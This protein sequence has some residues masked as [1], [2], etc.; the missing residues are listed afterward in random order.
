VFR[1]VKLKLYAIPGS[2]PCVAVEAALALKGLDYERVD[3]LPGLSPFHQLATFGKRTVPGMKIDGD[4]IVGSRLIMRALDGIAPEPPLYP[5]DADARAAAE[6]AERWGEEQLQ[7]AARW[8][9]VYAVG[10]R[11]ES[12]ASFTVGSNIPR[13]PG[14]LL[15]PLTRAIFAAELRVFA[16]GRDRA[17]TWLSELPGLL[18]HADRL[19]ADGV[20]GADPPG[21]ADLQIA[22]S[23]RL[24]LTLDDVREPIDARS[25][26]QLARRLLPDFPGEVP[27]GALPAQWLPD[28]TATAAPEPAAAR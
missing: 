14:V 9:S 25:C 4:K 7:E 12:A 5:R 28:L 21:A 10:H 22:S 18:D 27:A 17:R 26:G 16:G 13:M 8:T 20:I 2:H 1:P 24:L 15:E 19:I 3:M 11:P 23:V 6:E